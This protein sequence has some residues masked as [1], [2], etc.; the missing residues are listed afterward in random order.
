MIFRDSF[1]FLLRI[2][3]IYAT[4]SDRLNM[5]KIDIV[6]A[7]VDGS[8]R[9]WTRRRAKYNFGKEISDGTD[10]TRFASDNEIYFCIASILKYVPFCG[11]IFL[12]TDRQKPKFIDEFHEQGLCSKEKIK[13]V[14]HSEIFSGYEHGYPSFNSL[15]IE[16]LIWRINGLSRYFIYLNDDFFFNA[17]AKPEDF[18]LGDQ[19]VVCG[20][21][22]S[23][24]FIKIKLGLR[25]L[26]R[27]IFA[28]QPK[29]GHTVSQM[30]AANLFGFNNFFKVHHYPHIMDINIFRNFFKDYPEILEKQVSYRFRD[31]EQI[32]PVSL[33]V[34]AKIKNKEA[35]LCPD[36]SIAYLKNSKGI[37][38]FISSVE[39]EKI[40]YGCIQSLD[41][42]SEYEKEKIFFAMKKK[43]KIY[44]PESIFRNNFEN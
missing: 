33:A 19:I 21:W 18:L 15:S 27:K 13:I 34:H 22:E 28:I 14:D 37:D 43:F 10:A 32:N 6:I 41:Q 1:L 11:T 35:L 36:P 31:I 26:L 30:L 8:D 42:F 25:R 44:L 39:N 24:A 5:Q 9:A 7:W 3:S 17:S 2:F 16:S 29:A 4:G 20:H 38:D 23:S 12:V 40:N